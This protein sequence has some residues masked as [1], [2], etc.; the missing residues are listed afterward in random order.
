MSKP[1]ATKSSV[2]SVASEGKM[3]ARSRIGT[4]STVSRALITWAAGVG[5]QGSVML[6]WVASRT[7]DSIGPPPGTIVAS[8]LTW[9]SKSRAMKS[10]NCPMSSVEIA[11]SSATGPDRNVL[12]ITPMEQTTSIDNQMPRQLLA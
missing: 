8:P 6:S 12:N 4:S 3:P 9:L 7:S 2:P 5:S 11:P 10:R 1:A